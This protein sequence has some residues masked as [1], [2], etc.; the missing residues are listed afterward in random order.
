MNANL[1]KA[2]DFKLEVE[3]KGFILTVDQCNE[4]GTRLAIWDYD[5]W[6]T[7]DRAFV[8]TDIGIY[9]S[10]LVNPSK[11]N[12][13]GNVAIRDNMHLQMDINIKSFPQSDSYE[14][15]IFRCGKTDRD[16]YG[17]I[18]LHKE[19]GFMFRFTD[20]DNWHGYHPGTDIEGVT[21]NKWYTVE[22]DIT[23]ST[24]QVK[25]DDTVR[26]NAKKSKFRFLRIISDLVIHLHLECTL[27]DIH[28]HS[29]PLIHRDAFYIRSR[30]ISMPIVPVSESK[31]KSFLF[32][33]ENSSISIAIGFSATKYVSFIA[34]TQ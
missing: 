33:E 28:L 20:R 24:F 13:I 6:T 15:N 1:R 31:H 32:V 21:M 9:Q 16:R 7:G 30:V 11:N 4:I 34:I 14:A 23:Q 8:E 22:M 3:K 27:G 12:V 19:K 26:Y 18:F 29:I 25:V 5:W 17:A 2:I 10:N